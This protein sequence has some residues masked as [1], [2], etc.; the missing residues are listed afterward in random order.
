LFSDRLV[1]KQ[2][3]SKL[4][5]G[6]VKATLEDN[7]VAPRTRGRQAKQQQQQP[8]QLSGGQAA[9]AADDQVMVNTTPAG[10]RR[11]VRTSGQSQP[12]SSTKQ[13]AAKQ[14]T[15]GAA[16]MPLQVAASQDEDAT[17]KP[18]G[19]N[20]S[21]AAPAS[22]AQ[23]WSL[24]DVSSDD[25]SDD[26]EEADGLGVSQLA[27]SI[28][29]ALL[30]KQQHSSK[31]QPGAKQQLQQQQQHKSQQQ[32]SSQAGTSQ[33]EPGSTDVDQ[34]IELAKKRWRPAVKPPAAKPPQRAALQ[35]E[36]TAEK[37]PGL[38]KQ[39]SE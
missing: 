21:T 12:A 13:L 20:K 3:A 36:V 23:F 34:E 14:L 4:H 10:G 27:A 38:A 26:D 39:V 16:Y 18:E 29:A 7:A 24:A 5:A 22:Q 31:G 25:D 15:R 19:S 30:A 8:V 17:D 35:L 32:P 6:A 37:D 9:E 33:G 11:S 2:P 28:R 1:S